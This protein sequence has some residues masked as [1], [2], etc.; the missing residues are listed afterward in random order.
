MRKQLIIATVLAIVAGLGLGSVIGH[1]QGRFFD[2]KRNST[3]DDRETIKALGEKKIVL[4]GEHHTTASHHRAQLDVIRMLHKAGVKVA[5]GL[6]MFRRDSQVELDRWINGDLDPVAFEK[7]Y[8]DN[9]TYPWPLYREIFEYARKN[10]L[11][12]VG[13]NVPRDITR[14]VALAG[15]QSLSDDQRRRL[16]DV[17]CRVDKEY[18][19][20]IRKA[21]GG[22]GHGNMNFLYFCE[23]QMVW[24]NAMAVYA[25][26]Y[27]KSN[28]ERV[29]VI[30]AGAGHVRK[31]AIPYQIRS[32][33]DLAVAVILP[34]VPGSIDSATVDSGDADYIF[35][36]LN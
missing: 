36:D 27:L 17:A 2:L 13:L 21:Y 31:Q 30:L 29:M 12:M 28:P 3:I 9:W 11:P 15:Y 10:K 22:H 5:V 35:L 6:E 20:F 32:R 4:V 14:Q 25:L 16:G 18:M 26:E 1:E 34:E 8:Y 23:A 24:D 19:D 7:I 33:S